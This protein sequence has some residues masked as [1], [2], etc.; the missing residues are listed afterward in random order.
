M[1]PERFAGTQTVSSSKFVRPARIFLTLLLIASA[2][3][4]AEA[5]ATPNPDGKSY[6]S[7]SFTQQL[8]TLKA[9][10]DAAGKSADSLRAL[11]ETLPK[12][13]PVDANRRH[14]E[15]PTGPLA[16]HLAK[17]EKQADRENELK[18]ARAYLDSLAEEAS[19]LSSAPEPG[20][21]S[22]RSK[23]DAILARSE[24]S[25]VR[26]Q[27]WYEKVRERI[28]EFFL[29]LLERVLGRVGS[30]K[31]FGYILLWL[32]IAG[33]AILI[34]YLI[35]RNWFRAARAAEIELSGAAVPARSWQEWIFAGRE[36]AARGDYRTAVQC[37][38]W[39]AI[40]RL[41]DVGALS[42]DRAKTP[43]EFLRALTSGKAI[44]AQDAATRSR[45]L[46]KM[47]SRLEKTWYG[48]QIATEADFRDSL[49][50]L[51]TLGCQLP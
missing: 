36:A 30:Q 49:A 11:R 32:G 50:Q 45:A 6:D 37:A 15:V 42:A 4:L 44:L 25:H 28:N 34:A 8:Q 20:S 14:F 31:T 22:A 27:S 7:A 48:Y 24:Y 18:Q 46:A 5:A 29:N 12:S 9:S 21:A 47:T 19:S 43:R 26:Q 2:T 13:W 10:L 41:Q 35:F 39:A 33:A 17:A 38:Y 51:E 1:R 16:S 40:A 23:L 3:H